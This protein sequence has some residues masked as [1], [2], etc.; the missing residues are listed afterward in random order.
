MIDLAYVMIVIQLI[1]NSNGFEDWELIQFHRRCHSLTLF[2][3]PYEKK[4]TYTCNWVTLMP[5]PSPAR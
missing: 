4:V 5:P 3:H 1:M 2:T